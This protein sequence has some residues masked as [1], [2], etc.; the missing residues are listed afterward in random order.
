MT[1]GLYYLENTRE[2]I[3]DFDQLYDSMLKCKRSVSWKPGVKAFVLNGTENCLKMEEQLRNG[4]W[5]N[6]RPKPIL[7]TYPKRRECLSIPFRDRTYQR[8]INDNALYPQATRHFIF[9][10]VACQ[11]G[12]G[13]QV[14]MKLMERYLKRFYIN[15]KTNKGFVVWIDIHG[16]YPNMKHELVNACFDR[17]CDT[18]TASMAKAV[19]DSQY[20]GNIG[21]NPGSQMVQIAGISLLNN[22]DHFIKEG[23][24][25]K[26]YIRYMDDMFLITD[27]KDEAKNWLN[28]VCDKLIE[29]GFEP[30]PKKAKV[31]RID[32]GF[33]YLGFKTTLSNTGKVY[34]NLNSQNIKHERRKLKKQVILS[35]QGRLPRAEVDSSYK[36]W[37]AHASCGNSIRLLKRMD[38]YYQHL[39]KEIKA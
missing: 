36:C 12:K 39:W 35:K 3:T 34:F 33:M 26:S 20:S 24:K 13:P 6:R 9:A 18:E 19:L 2:Y 30:N 17:L 8:S 10:N 15:R 25:C 16:Y 22:L 27:D 23:L 21:Y 29:L 11:K 38:D 5:K 32:K 14:A 7:I 1:E 31:C 37:K 28:V 4:L